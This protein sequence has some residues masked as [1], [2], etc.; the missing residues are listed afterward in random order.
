LP[1]LLFIWFITAF[2]WDGNSYKNLRNKYDK[3]F[4]ESTTP[5]K[6]H[7]ENQMPASAPLTFVIKK[8]QG[9]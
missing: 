9:C 8:T 2:I 7:A 5:A 4:K 3:H 1:L 6:H